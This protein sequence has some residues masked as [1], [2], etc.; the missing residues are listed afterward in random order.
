VTVVSDDSTIYMCSFTNSYILN[1]TES[2]SFSIEGGKLIVGINS[3]CYFCLLSG[4]GMFKLAHIT[5]HFS[6]DLK[7]VVQV[8]AGN[9]VFECVKIFDESLY[10]KSSLVI[11]RPVLFSCSITFL[12]CDFHNFSYSTPT[13]L[14]SVID[15]SI[16]NYN[17]VS[18]N[19]SFSSF[20][21]GVLTGIYYGGIGSYDNS[22]ALSGFSFFF[23]YLFFY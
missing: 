4:I 15:I 14:S 3:S 5:L 10:W 16:D 21:D 11:V 12:F 19:I 8:E 20:L 18:L 2:K 17:P 22:N 9:L 23:F 6:N 13:N 1:I 7:C